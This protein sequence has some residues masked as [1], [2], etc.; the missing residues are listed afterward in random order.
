MFMYFW[1]ISIAEI[2]NLRI[3]SSEY[4]Y[5]ISAPSFTYASPTSKNDLYLYRF[6]LLPLPKYL[7]F[8]LY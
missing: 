3:R 4:I 2:L 5:T 7:G 6:F 8:Y 1:Y